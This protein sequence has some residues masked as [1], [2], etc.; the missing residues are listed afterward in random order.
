MSLAA[1]FVAL[2]CGQNLLLAFAAGFAFGGNIALGF[3][4]LA[5]ACLLGK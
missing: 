3:F 2:C 5:L 4:F 1:F